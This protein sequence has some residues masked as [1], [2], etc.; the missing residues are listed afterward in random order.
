MILKK[1]DP[2]SKFLCVLFIS[3][4]KEETEA[5]YDQ[6]HFHKLWNG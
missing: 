2:F 3:L 5:S 4:S 6:I 1:K